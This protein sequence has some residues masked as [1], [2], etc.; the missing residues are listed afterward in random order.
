MAD[1]NRKYTSD[2]KEY[3]ECF[4]LSESDHRKLLSDMKSAGMDKSKYLR[5]L[6][7]SCGK[8]D[9]TFPQDRAHMIRQI[10]GIANNINQIA[11][12]ANTKSDI[13]FSDIDELK[14]LMEEIRNLLKEVLRVWQLRRS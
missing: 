5:L 10:S 12:V 2:K 4:K 6:V 3:K 11:K 7:Q 13:Y 8:V 1:G 14:R 9:A